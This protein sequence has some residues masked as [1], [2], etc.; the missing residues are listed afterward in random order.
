MSHCIER[1]IHFLHVLAD[2]SPKTAR[3]II[4]KEGNKDL[5]CALTEIFHNI[6]DSSI[7]LSETGR[8]AIR[9]KYRIIKKLAQKSKNFRQKHQLMVKYAPEFLNITLPAVLN[10]L[11]GSH[12]SDV[13]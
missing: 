7:T 6:L 12:T 13:S 8:F 10:K 4:L 3:I 1:S 9:K 2:V 5:I 11:N